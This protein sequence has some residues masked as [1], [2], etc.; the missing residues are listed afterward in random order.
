[1]DALEDAAKTT[2]NWWGQRAAL[3]GR[4]SAASLSL[5][6]FQFVCQRIRVVN[7]AQRFN[8]RGGIYR[9]GAR[10]FYRCKYSRARATEC[11]RRK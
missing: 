11:C 1:M 6:A 9:D 2:L 8:D 3:S 10:L 7:F 4:R 5:S